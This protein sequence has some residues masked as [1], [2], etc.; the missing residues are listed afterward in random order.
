M[1]RVVLE[2]GTRDCPNAWLTYGP[3]LA[4]LC[5][6]TLHFSSP[7]RAVCAIV[8]L[9]SII[10]MSVDVPRSECTHAYHM[11][12]NNTVLIPLVLDVEINQLTLRQKI[13]PAA[14]KKYLTSRI[15]TLN[16]EAKL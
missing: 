13:G 8:R 11:I 6:Q 3:N 10:T 4:M 12:E 16:P 5:S 7:P 9:P 14:Q 1:L 15:T 2:W